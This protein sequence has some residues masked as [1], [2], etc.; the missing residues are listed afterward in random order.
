MVFDDSDSVCLENIDIGPFRESNPEPLPPKGRIIPLDQ[1]ADILLAYQ[2]TEMDWNMV[3][4]TMKIC[5]VRLH[6]DLV[7]VSRSAFSEIFF[8]KQIWNH[9]WSHLIKFAHVDR[10]CGRCHVQSSTIM[11]REQTTFSAGIWPHGTH[12]GGALRSTMLEKTRGFDTRRRRIRSHSSE[13]SGIKFPFGS[14]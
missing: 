14:L 8:E 9:D 4:H 10:M 1:T 3:N 6:D 12:R 13:M 2:N 7:K 11:Q 5:G